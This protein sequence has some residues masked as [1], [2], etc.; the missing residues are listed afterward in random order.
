M[1]LI[2]LSLVMP[3]AWY[4]RQLMRSATS[5]ASSGAERR[6]GAGDAVSDDRSK[7]STSGCRASASITGGT[8]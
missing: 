7:S 6:R 2:G 4:T 1:W 8:A 3:N 5:V